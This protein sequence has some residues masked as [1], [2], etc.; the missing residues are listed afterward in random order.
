[1]VTQE[2]G[3][4]LYILEP[5]F[6]FNEMQSLED[7][8]NNILYMSKKSFVFLIL[9]CLWDFIRNVKLNTMKFIHMLS[10]MLYVICH[11]L[12]SWPLSY[13]I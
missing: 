2:Y 3:M 4:N 13:Y 5:F 7:V 6:H 8:S 11:D 10:Y 1:M 12:E 9:D